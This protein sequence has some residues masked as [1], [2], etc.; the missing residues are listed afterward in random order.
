M[1]GVHNLTGYTYTRSIKNI[2]K[3]TLGN[4]DL[5]GVLWLFIN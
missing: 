5:K 1:T 2:K 3:F 4:R